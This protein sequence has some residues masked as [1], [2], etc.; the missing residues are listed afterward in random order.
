[1]RVVKVRVVVVVVEVLVQGVVDQDQDQTLNH[2]IIVIQK[3]INVIKRKP[4]KTSKQ[5]KSQNK[6]L[7]NN[8]DANVPILLHHH[9]RHHHH[10][11]YP[12]IARIGVEVKVGQEVFQGVLHFHQDHLILDHHRHLL[13]IK[14]ITTQQVV[15]K[16]QNHLDIRNEKQPKPIDAHVIAN[17]NRLHHLHLHQDQD[18]D[19]IHHHHRIRLRRILLLLLLLIRL[20]HQDLDLDRL[21]LDE[22][23]VVVVYLLVKKMRQQHIARVAQDQDQDQDQKLV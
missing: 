22:E 5:P 18:Q 7:K 9:H 23:R 17:I 1:M 10:R 6:M 21:M 2:Q 14:N 19:H 11:L 20:I 16:R 15:A 8:V 12:I 3:R 4:L 13:Q